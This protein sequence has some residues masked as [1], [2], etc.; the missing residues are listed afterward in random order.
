MLRLRVKMVPVSVATRMYNVLGRRR[1]SGAGR[2][3]RR[4]VMLCS[5]ERSREITI[6]VCD[7]AVLRK[8]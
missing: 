7:S 8:E 4:V 1:S 6:E 2:D 3:R 5:V